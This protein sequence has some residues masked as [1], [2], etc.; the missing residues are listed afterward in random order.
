MLD[1]HYYFIPTSYLLNVIHR[2]P[3]IDLFENV[4]FESGL[5][6]VGDMFY[7]VFPD[8]FST[9]VI[10]KNRKYQENHIFLM[11]IMVVIF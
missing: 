8:G 11:S 6:F 4:A 7:C 5:L 1:I 9:F 10:N 3:S 2:T